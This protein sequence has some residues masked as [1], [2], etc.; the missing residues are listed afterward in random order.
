MK[1]QNQWGVVESPRLEKHIGVSLVL[2]VCTLPDLLDSSLQ[3]PGQESEEKHFGILCIPLAPH[4][5]SWP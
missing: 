2:N 3:S 5:S 4:R 1:N